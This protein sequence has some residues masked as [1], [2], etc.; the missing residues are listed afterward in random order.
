KLYIKLIILS[1]F[2]YSCKNRN[3]NFIHVYTVG[4]DSIYYCRSEKFSAKQIH[5]SK[6]DD[7]V[8]MNKFIKDFSDKIILFKPLGGDCAGGAETVMNFITLLKKN[9]MNYY[10]GNPDAV[11]EQYFKE[12]SFFKTL[13]KLSNPDL[14]KL[15]EPAKPKEAKVNDI[16]LFFT[17][18]KAGD[19]FYELKTQ[20]GNTKPAKVK[21]ASHEKIIEIIS[22][23]ENE[24]KVDVKNTKAIINVSGSTPFSAIMNLQKALATKGI[25]KISYTTTE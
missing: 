22:L 10:T 7:S 18:N 6:K 4:C 15:N 9:K 25:Y 19:L 12:S 13:E 20:D 17:I 14:I 5:G 8:F 11:E 23:L 16:F 24:H 3:T 21:P 2:L 1:F